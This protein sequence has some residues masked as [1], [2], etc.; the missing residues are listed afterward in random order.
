[1]RN[2]FNNGQQNYAT[3]PG[4]YLQYCDYSESENECFPDNSDHTDLWN[5]EKRN[6]D[7]WKTFEYIPF[8]TCF[9]KEQSLDGGKVIFDGNGN[10]ILKY[11]IEEEAYRRVFDRPIRIQQTDVNPINENPARLA[12]SKT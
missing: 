6:T 7:P 10:V 5:Y 8:D 12:C 11:T 1:M 4:V 9:Q 2:E 3:V